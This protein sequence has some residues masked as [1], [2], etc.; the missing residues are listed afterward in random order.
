M[1]RDGGDNSQFGKAIEM[2]NRVL[3]DAA[4]RQSTGLL[5]VVNALSDDTQ[6]PRI[7]GGA[8]RD[9]LLNLPV[10]DIDLAT[11]LLPGDVT[12]RLEANRIKAV[13]TG[14]D[15]GTITAVADD[16]S[17]EITTLR[18]DVATDGRHAVVAFATD[19]QEDA[20]RRDFTINA[21]YAD[22]VSGEIFDYFGG[23]DD[24]QNQY[25]R[26]IG[27]PAQRIAED[28]LRILRYFRFL[29]RFGGTDV[30]PIAV[31][32][33]AG[34]ANSLMALSRERIAGE[35]TKILLVP[36]PSFAIN[37]MIEHN[38]FDPFLPEL[39]P[40]AIFM[41]TRL[42]MREREYQLLPSLPARILT[43]LP[44]DNIIADK[45]AFRLKMSNRIR[46]ELGAILAT[47]APAVDT[48]RIAAYRHTLASARNSVMVYADDDHFRGCMEQLNGWDIPQFT[49]KGGDLIARGLTAGPVVA[50]TLK[51]I[52][53]AWIAEQFP[54][55]QR[56]N[57][58]TDQ[59]VAGALLETKNA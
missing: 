29:A 8:V 52:E 12:D 19:W 40:T 37:L 33:C 56:L 45:V 58:I 15:H 48:I 36:D 1:G 31:A 53:T 4:W 27:D 49:V 7:V 9:S 14:L 25:L 10:S 50:R 54:G 34:A 13:P 5:R 44:C 23:L 41:L 32:A 57:A 18:R 42:V 47:S 16:Q 35:L 51:Q 55:D 38:I 20:S 2:T 43:L 46:T 24:L 21:L 26:F 39:S 11:I 30:E 59:F 6:K 17:F 22:P 3:P 28:H